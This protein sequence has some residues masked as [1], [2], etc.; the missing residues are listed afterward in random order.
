M[1]AKG[2]PLSRAPNMGRSRPVLVI[3]HWLQGKLNRHLKRLLFVLGATFFVCLMLSKLFPLHAPLPVATVQLP[4]HVHSALIAL[5]NEAP[6]ALVNVIVQRTNPDPSLEAAVTHLGGRV[7]RRLTLINALVVQLP[8]RAVIE[9]GS[10]PGVRW[11]SLDSVAQSS[12]CFWCVNTSRLATAYIPTIG[13]DKV[14]NRAPYLQGQRV[15]V[16]VVDSGISRQYDLDGS[17]W[18][19]H[20]LIAEAVYSGDPDGE[21]FYGHGDHVAR[22]I[23][24]N[25]GFSG[26]YIGVAP[27]V[28]LVNVKVANDEGSAKISDVISGLQWIFDNRERYNI[29]VVNISMNDSV[30]ESYHTSALD[31]AVEMLWFNGIVVVVSAGNTGDGGIYAPANDP[32]V[33]TV[34]ATDDR[35]TT[36]IADDVMAPFSA[37][38]ATIDGY[39]KPDIVAPGTNIVSRIKNRNAVLARQHPDHIVQTS[40]RIGTYFRMSGTSMS[41]PMVSGAA[42]LLIQSNPNLTPDQVKY[43]LMHTAR[44][45]DAPLRAGAGYLD[46]DAAVLGDST[47]KENQ[48]LQISHILWD[49]LTPLIWNSTTQGSVN[50]R[51]HGTAFWGTASQ[52]SDVNN[53]VIWGS[54]Y[55]DNVQSAQVAEPLSAASAQGD[56]NF[57]T[58]DELGSQ[59]ELTELIVAPLDMSLFNQHVFLP[60]IAAATP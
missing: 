17:R 33:I 43:R 26:E 52:N 9:L 57:A 7:I 51:G 37:Y 53:S 49:A 60:L 27:E 1:H 12:L 28:N 31:A 36:D 50:W 59:L 25:G 22:I 47:Q 35:G 8:A 24:S 20:R 42:A 46:V 58:G 3:R 39:A 45:F 21:D 48:D 6:T 56:D 54:D 41:T 29:R 30:L 32:F 55:W 14:W 13:A 19:F 34:G 4:T 10:D 18:S 16:A 2:A 44:P 15:G 23:G 11:I 40:R 38:G 5:A